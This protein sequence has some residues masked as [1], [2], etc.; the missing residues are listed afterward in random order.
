MS[1][2]QTIKTSL[3]KK[4]VVF[5]AAACITIG[6]TSAIHAQKA[7]FSGEWKLNEAKSTLGQFSRMA[8][9]KL[10]VDGQKDS[11]SVQRFATSP[12]GNEVAYNEKLSFDGKETESTVFGNSKKKSIAKWADDGQSLTIN[13]TL[14]FERDGQSF[15]VK[16]TEIWKLMESGKVLSL[17]STSTSQMGTNTTNLLFDKAG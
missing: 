17:E 8:P 13:S 4:A 14:V 7:N 5:S 6:S 12:D 11:L 15:E 10:K 16:V 1:I 9:R 3:W 2:H